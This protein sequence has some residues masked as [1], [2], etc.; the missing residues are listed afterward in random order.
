M[1]RKI[2]KQVPKPHF[3]V[4]L[5]NYDRDPALTAAEVS[6]IAAFS[7][8]G[9]R[10][11]ALYPEIVSNRELNRLINPLLD[12]FGSIKHFSKTYNSPFSKCHTLIFMLKEMDRR[13]CAYWSWTAKDWA[14]ILCRSPYE[15]NRRYKTEGSFRHALINVA[16]F[17]GSFRDFYQIGRFRRYDYAVRFFGRKAVDQSLKPVTEQLVSWGYN[18]PAVTNIRKVV[19]EIMICNRSPRLEDIT[20][21]LLLETRERATYQC[22]GGRG[23]KETSFT[24]YIMPASKVLAALG[25][26]N[27]P[28]DMRRRPDPAVS[29]SGSQGVPG[30]WE[31]WCQRWSKTSTYRPVTVEATVVNVRL[32]GRWLAAEHPDIKGPE[33]WTR[34]TAAE[35]VAA[36][37]KAKIGQWVGYSTNPNRG[38]PLSPRTICMYLSSLRRFFRDCQEWEWIPRRFNPER[39]FSAPRSLTGLIKPSPRTVDDLTW[40]KLL[41]AG[42]ELTA[43]D[44]YR[45]PSKSKRPGR[46]RAHYP[47][48]MVKAVAVVW[49]FTGLRTDEMR[50]LRVG[51]ASRKEHKRRTAKLGEVVTRD[52]VC[53]LEVPANK[54]SASFVKPVD[55]VVGEAIA[56]WERVRP[57]APPAVDPKTRAT[58][59]YL[60]TYRLRRIGRTF[61]NRRLIPLLCAKAGVAGIDS[62]G[63]I[64]SHRARATI[65]TILN[66]AEVPMPVLDIQRW[67][68]HKYMESTL[69]YLQTRGNL[70]SSYQAAEY[71]SSSLRRLHTLTELTDK[72]PSAEET[73]S[74]LLELKHSLTCIRKSPNLE[75]EQAASL[76][77][78]IKLLEEIYISLT[79]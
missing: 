24:R 58:V 29:N 55:A 16:Y 74:K 47:I 73:N 14:A 42:L 33:S 2:S 26:I 79:S 34:A 4:E 53:F 78:N 19:C 37:C 60:F 25:V 17:L 59:N 54:T 48:E 63:S 12:V 32:A 44:I 5:F 61:I 41:R 72:I 69:H 46:R 6:S 75:V 64:T 76:D 27:K 18:Q 7:A 71:L 45:R 30:E 9:S 57:A 36:I 68:G 70:A 8:R 10:A 51:C 65:A 40:L 31:E 28:L 13:Q 62:S 3:G 23:L 77:R 22:E 21:E 52:P 43:E 56:A 67:L 39:A 35:F 15:F 66:N 50:R 11:V 20:Y 1:V 38:K 49:L